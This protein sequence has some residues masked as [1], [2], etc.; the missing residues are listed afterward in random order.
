MGA[1]RR[2]QLPNNTT[3]DINDSRIHIY[4]TATGTAATSETHTK[5]DIDDSKISSYVDGMVVCVK[6]P[7][8]G[9]GSYGVGIQIGSLGYKPVVYNVNTTVGNRYDTGSIIW[10]VY[11]STQSANMYIN[12]TNTTIEGCWQ[13]MDYDISYA[14]TYIYY[15]TILS[16]TDG[17]VNKTLIMPTVDGTW[18]SVTN[19][20]GYAS[21]KGFLLSDLLF[22]YNSASNLAANTIPDG[23]NI[24]SYSSGL[25]KSDYLKSFTGNFVA[26]KPIYLVGTI[27]NDGFFH[28]NSSNFITQTLPS[29][30]DGYLYLFVGDA[31]STSNFQLFDQ[32]PVYYHNGNHICNYNSFAADRGL[33]IVNGK[34]G[35][36]NSITAGS[37]DMGYDSL[38]NTLIMPVVSYDAYGHISSNTI[39]S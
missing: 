6:V 39:N 26:G 12:G 38:E 30:A 36:S 14:N 17:L 24:Y 33:S 8:A 7:V 21:T 18:S 13:V 11:N 5:W 19:A 27:G 34:I 1:L 20:D 37:V 15:Q 25:A 29:T 2:I 31:A 23:S 4:R 16:G 35:H 32:H 22:V 3:Y 28:L 9:N 10:A